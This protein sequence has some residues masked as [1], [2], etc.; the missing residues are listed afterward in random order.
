M[1]ME[2]SS[3][4]MPTSIRPIERPQ[5]T[6]STGGV[7]RRG[8]T[9]SAFAPRTDVNIK[10]SIA[11]MAGI[12]SKISSNQ[13]SSEEALSPQLQKLIDTIMKQS[14]SLESTLSEG[15]G[16]TLESQ[17]F[18]VDQMLTLSRLLSQLGNLTEQG[19]T[20][21][22]SPSVEAF[23]SAL[24]ETFASNAS[25]LSP[26]L[27]HK[28]AFEMLDEKSVEKLPETLKF[29]L[30][31][32]SAFMANGGAGTQ[33]SSSPTLNF[34]KQLMRYFM[35][36]ASQ[37]TAEGSSDTGTGTKANSSARQEAANEA[38][39]AQNFGSTKQTEAGNE[40]NKAS[41]NLGDAFR[42]AMMKDAGRSESSQSTGLANNQA[43]ETQKMA[44]ARTNNNQG[45]HVNE[46][47]KT[48]QSESQQNANINENN[49]AQ[50]TASNQNISQ[51]ESNT[52]KSAVKLNGNE[53]GNA[54]SEETKNQVPQ[55]EQKVS[56]PFNV[57][58]NEQGRT[59]GLKNQEA[60][61]P[62]TGKAQ[63]QNQAQQSQRAQQSQQTQQAQQNQQTGNTVR[64]M[65][66]QPLEN[67][68]QTMST[69]KQ[70]ASLLL[71]DAKLSQQDMTLLQNFVNGRQNTLSEKD[72]KQLQLLLRLCQ[73]N[74]PASV[75]QAAVQGN[76]PDLPR[77]WA[78]MELCDLVY[79][80]EKKPSALKKAG[81][82]I[83]DFASMMKSSLSPRSSHASEGTRSMSFMMPLYM[84]EN[85]KIPY[86]A[87]IHIYDEEEDDPRWPG[88]KK[89]ETWLRVCLL[90]ENI[91]A[92]DVT[93]RMY[94][95]HNVDVRVIFSDS[96]SVNDFREY[97]DEF[98]SSFNEL[99]LNLM[100]LQIGM[101]GMKK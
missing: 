25:E 73:N 18:S 77:L 29:F 79:L 45:N 78:F 28:A 55:N 4:S 57:E 86:P 15:L 89:K 48:S 58:K 100:D 67:T 26:A 20:S 50:S 75:Q 95:E 38:T 74:M 9:G 19:A 70:L 37:N 8:D 5:G 85:E 81:K 72:A 54:A 39:S 40:S 96:E 46:D 91:G 34:I 32:A 35:P 97:I 30:M 44:D 51:S 76:M 84:G 17:R 49:K 88:N 47:R 43:D 27:L 98:R 31:N 80:K 66:Q 90:T 10:S 7:T 94:E 56:D 71:K 61:N 53:S 24:K 23:L 6:Q 63:V 13:T 42:E 69:M 99:P 41:Q 11:D 65:M 62:N 36:S 12:L 16:S 59:N 21:E 3:A 1:P 22:L 60:N 92:V 93:F 52:A 68:P 82:D 101:T 83:A 33:A 14:F 64:Q 2:T 87:Y